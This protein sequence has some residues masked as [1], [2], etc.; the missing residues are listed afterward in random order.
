MEVRARYTLIGLFALAVISAGF[1]FIYWL[2]AGGGLGARVSYRVRFDGPVAGLL[3][4]S[5]VLFNGVRVGEVTAL[6]LDAAQPSDV[7]VEIAVDKS[8]PVRAD[9]TVGIDFQGLAGAPAIAMAGGTAASP[10]LSEGQPAERVLAAQKHAGESLVQAGREVLRR[11][12]SV[13]SENQEPLRNAIASIDKFSAA[14]ARN[15]DK[16]DGILAGLERLTG[17]GAKPVVRIYDLSAAQTFPPLRAIPKSQLVVPEP[18]ALAN[19]EAEK[20]LVTGAEKQSLENAQWPDMLPRVVQARIVQSFENAGY[21]NVLAGPP[22]GKR[23]DVQLMIDIRRFQLA[24]G[25]EPHASIEIAA[26][27][28]DKDGGIIGARTFSADAGVKSLETQVAVT[29]LNEAFSKAT[30]DLI[31]W[32]C[33]VL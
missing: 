5:A 30:V 8:A 2:D 26:K 1:A 18:T 15:S 29:A 23:A 14:L 4:G 22:E 28:L 7:V 20:I 31:V 16:V 9:T 21:S 25:A 32:A 12:D 3:K 10:L 24:A 33:G 13:V 27:L 19:F 11:L 6:N 17:G